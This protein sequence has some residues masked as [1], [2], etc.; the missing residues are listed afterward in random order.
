MSA[1]QQLEDGA[2]VD[3]ARQPQHARGRDRNGDRDPE[4]PRRERARQ[5]SLAFDLVRVGSLVMMAVVLLSGYWKP[6]PLVSLA[7]PAAAVVLW[8]PVIRTRRVERWLLYYVAGIYLY[9]VLRALA[10]EFGFPIRSDYV[11]AADRLLFGGVVPSVALQ[12]DFFSPS[13]VD[14]LDFSA[15]AIHASFFVVPHAAAAYIWLRHPRA[16]P[17]YVAC[18]LL[19]LYIGLALFILLPTVPP[20]LATRRGDL[21][22]T[23]RVLDFVLRG[24]DIDA[25][26]SL[27]R[28][29]AEPNAVASVPSIHMAITCVVMLRSRDFAP[30][31]FW[32]LM[33][34][35]VAMALALIYLG[36][37][38]AFDLIVGTGV[39]IAVEIAV[40]WTLRRRHRLAVARA[41]RVVD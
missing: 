22:V 30:R 38:Y 13:D 40:R 4:P 15:T 8:I 25:Y 35:A 20:W 34:Y 36:E 37:H 29:L 9:T 32:P 21:A 31:W 5:Q 41:V 28:T 24:V 33:L 10:D 3:G 18:V 2:R 14:W 6:H 11:I 23:Y 39:A 27:Y 17:D 1:T 19:T 26:R 16:L 12:H 7:V